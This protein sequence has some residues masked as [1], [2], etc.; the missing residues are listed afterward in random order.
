M[1]N[2][3]FIFVHQREACGTAVSGSAADFM[4]HGR[5]RV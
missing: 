2:A 4:W 1:M 5:M 3:Q